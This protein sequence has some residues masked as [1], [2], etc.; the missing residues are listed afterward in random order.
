MLREGED[1]ELVLSATDPEGREIPQ[2]RVGIDVGTVTAVIRGKNN[3]LGERTIRYQIK[4]ALT[5]GDLQ[6]V[7]YNGLAQVLTPSV[8]DA[9]DA[10]VTLVEGD[11]YTLTVEG[12]ATDVTAA[13]VTVTVRGQG[14]YGG[15]YVRTYR[16]APYAITLKSDD[17]SW[18]YD[19]EEHF[20]GGVTVVEGEVQGFDTLDAEATGA[21][22]H[23]RDTREGNNSIRFSSSRW[24]PKH[25]GALRR[26]ARAAELPVDV[27]GNY[28]VTVLPVTL[29]ILPRAIT[30]TSADASR[31]FDG[32]PLVRH[33]VTT[34]LSGNQTQPG[35]V[36]DDGLAYAFMGTRTS[37]G[38]SP[39]EFVYAFAQGTDSADYEVEKVLGSLRVSPADSVVVHVRGGKGRYTFNGDAQVVSGWVSD[40][41]EIDPEISIV[42][43]DGVVA[44]ASAK[45]PGRYSMGL[46]AADFVAQSPNYGKVLVEVEDGE[47]VIERREDGKDGG[48]DPF[49]HTGGQDKGRRAREGAAGYAGRGATFRTAASRTS[50]DDLL[51]QTGDSQAAAGV[52]GL[53]A[54]LGSALAGL[55][56]TLKRR[57]RQ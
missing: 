3:Y 48:S 6:D 21:V 2:D 30:L 42:L 54:T 8:E 49:A 9:Q 5:V 47:L 11:D 51:P 46:S 29:T 35:L 36:G 41:A 25:A 7:V 10:A 20:V 17:G 19:G 34:H 27:A 33:E 50:G 31:T 57:P 28:A 26:V 52:S 32:T 37:A 4:R 39:N 40:A 1:Y 13:G 53:L 56:L 22:T 43:R 18:I 16:I 55:G 45:E 38:V 12:N 44:S 14:A 24:N 15:S 23:V